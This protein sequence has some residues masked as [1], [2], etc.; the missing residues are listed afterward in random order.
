M[1]IGP[2]ILVYT[3][4]LVVAIAGV[5]LVQ[6][7]LARRD[8]RRDRAVIMKLGANVVG[9]G[10]SLLRAYRATFNDRPPISSDEFRKQLSTG[11]RVTLFL[12]I[13]IALL[14]GHFVGRGGWELVVFL[15]ALFIVPAFTLPASL[16]HT[17]ILRLL[18]ARGPL[19][20]IGT[21]VFLGVIAPAILSQ[22]EIVKVSAIYG[23][24]YGLI[25]GL[26][27]TAIVAPG[28]IPDNRPRTL[29][30]QAKADGL[31]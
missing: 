15:M 7:L 19:A 14:G 24:V 13:P 29:E 1:E 18:G 28:L 4:W 8:L 27:N 16:V 26:G 11:F 20:S 12:V 5:G 21:G 25:V 9:H 6:H 23:G 17:H 2:Q 22:P 30:E 3:A 31:L 10:G